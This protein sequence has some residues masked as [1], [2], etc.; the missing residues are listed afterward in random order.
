MMADETIYGTVQNGLGHLQDGVG[1]LAGDDKLQAKGK[2]NRV[3]GS[4]RQAYGKVKDKAV[5]AKE[6]AGETYARAKLTAQGSV[7]DVEA[8]IRDK[9]LFAMGV[10][11]GVGV[12]VG[13]ILGGGLGAY[14]AREYDRRR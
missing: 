9:P 13:M 7:G 8:R 5:V 11:A 6:K 3:A 12:L 10:V 14:G 1:G 2:L 4:A